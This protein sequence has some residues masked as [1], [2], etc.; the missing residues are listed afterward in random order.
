MQH[1]RET[2]QSH[3]RK[4]GKHRRRKPKESPDSILK[5][6]VTLNTSNT[7]LTR[8]QLHLPEHDVYNDPHCHHGHKLII[9]EYNKGGAYDNG[10]NCDL[11]S[12]SYDCTNE[13]IQRWY[14][15]SCPQ[16]VCFRAAPHAMPGMTRDPA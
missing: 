8:S 15:V 9:S 3:Q 2:R 1:A 11:C 16:D 5:N 4:R 6:M 14:C 12:K 13:Q 7:R 10:W